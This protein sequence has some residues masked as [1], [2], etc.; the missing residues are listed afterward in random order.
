[1]RDNASGEA[2]ICEREVSKKKVHGSVKSRIHEDEN[3]DE[4][5]S[6][7]SQKINDEK[8]NK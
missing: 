1:M 4:Q 7:H 8:K 5:V 6:K 2:E 3:D